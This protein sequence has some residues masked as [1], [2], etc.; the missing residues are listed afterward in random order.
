[1]YI[2]GTP[3]KLEK[4]AWPRFSSLSGVIVFISHIV[5]YKTY[6]FSEDQKQTVPCIGVFGGVWGTGVKRRRKKRRS[7]RREGD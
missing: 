4:Y 7:R 2:S 1:V 6:C 3:D 5:S